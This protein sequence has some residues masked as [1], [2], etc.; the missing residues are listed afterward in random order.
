M[1]AGDSP[2]AA[3]AVGVHSRRLGT[4]LAP[5][6]SAAMLYAEWARLV[7]GGEPGSGQVRGLEDDGFLVE[8]DETVAL[9]DVRVGEGGKATD[10][11]E[12]RANR[13][14]V[15]IS[16]RLIM[17]APC[18]PA[19]GC[20]T[21]DSDSGLVR[22]VQIANLP[23]REPQQNLIYELRTEQQITR[24]SEPDGNVFWDGKSNYFVL[25]LDGIPDEDTSLRLTITYADGATDRMTMN[26]NAP[27][28]GPAGATTT[29]G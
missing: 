7:T 23:I 24:I 20:P 26:F 27:T 5:P 25:Q 1:A 6:G 22:A 2:E 15:L 9:R 18:D 19:P 10:V 3:Y 17:Q 8:V 16:D 13:P 4:D 28:E 11:R 12:C 29:T 21:V 14:C